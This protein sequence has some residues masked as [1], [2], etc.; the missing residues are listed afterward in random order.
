MVKLIS[1]TQGAGELLNK[2]AQEIIAYTARVSNPNNQMNFETAPKLLAYLI[3]HKHWSPYEMSHLTLEIT[4]S[5]AIAAQILRHRSFS[6]QEFSQRYSE[7][8]DFVLYEPRK[9]DIKNKQNSIDDLPSEDMDWFLNAMIG[10]QTT[11][12]VLYKEALSR[13][14]AKECARF[15]LPLNT[16]TTMYMCGSLRSWIHYCEVRCDASTQ[17]E[18]R[19]IALACRNIVAEQFPDV[20]KAL[21]WA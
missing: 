17:L 21:G 4:T 6:F 1:V 14:V 11:A 12:K 15:L 3:K 13:G 9:Q 16:Q 8:T 19:E 2:N 20:A 10:V 5:R 18:H 7:A